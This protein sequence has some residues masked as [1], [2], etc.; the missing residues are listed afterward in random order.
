M[1]Q[2]RAVG[3]DGLQVRAGAVLLQLLQDVAVE[4][5]Q[6]RM[7]MHVRSGG[8]M[9]RMRRM[10]TMLLEVAVALGVAVEQGVQAGASGS[11]HVCPVDVRPPVQH[12]QHGQTG[13][14]AQQ[15]QHCLGALEVITLGRITLL[16]ILTLMTR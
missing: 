11:Q 7:R 10:D 5:M 9:L 4:G 8:T 14:A 16:M 1:A 12:L 3:A 13:R 15:V 2:A 6:A